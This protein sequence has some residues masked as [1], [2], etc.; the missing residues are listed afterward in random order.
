MK[1]TDPFRVQRALLKWLPIKM[2]FG[3]LER[4]MIIGAY[5]NILRH[6]E[7]SG[8]ELIAQL[9]ESGLLGP[10]GDPSLV[11]SELISRDSAK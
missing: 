9:V 3:P 10:E 7:K 11:L 2:E 6:A 8:P 5:R 1:T 4:F